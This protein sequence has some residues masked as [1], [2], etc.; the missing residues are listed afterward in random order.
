RRTELERDVTGDDG[1]PGGV[2][3]ARR[4]QLLARDDVRRGEQWMTRRQLLTQAFDGLKGRDR[5]AGVR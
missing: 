5:G 2:D 3:N 4:R 1:A